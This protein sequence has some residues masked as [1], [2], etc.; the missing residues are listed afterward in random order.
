MKKFNILEVGNSQL[1]NHHYPVEYEVKTTT[2]DSLDQSKIYYDASDS[3]INLIHRIHR[4]INEDQLDLIVFSLGINP[5][6]TFHDVNS[7]PSFR[8]VFEVNFFNIVDILQS[9][10]SM[11]HEKLP[12]K[13]ISFLFVSSVAA[14]NGYPFHVAYAS[15]KAALSSLC[16][17]L[18]M[19]Y[20]SNPNINFYE[21]KP[22]MVNTKLSNNRGIDSE[23]YFNTHYLSLL[24]RIKFESHK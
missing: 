2:R 21:L 15:S 11:M 24:E 13:K 20:E 12:D 10:I 14:D 8:R 17:S 18:K 19:E 22:P 3:H 6:N 4:V 23:E 9:V 5:K 7:R 1:L 16:T